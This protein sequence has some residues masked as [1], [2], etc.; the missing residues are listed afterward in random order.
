MKIAGAKITRSPY[1][2]LGTPQLLR[3]RCQCATNTT[4]T[5]IT[6]SATISTITSHIMRY[7]LY[8]DYLGTAIF[9]TVCELF[10]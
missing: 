1:G 3:S 2:Q 7:L 6:T 9:E 4:T 8:S 10:I 5:T